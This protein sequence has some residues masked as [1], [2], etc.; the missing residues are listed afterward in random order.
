[1]LH[2][3]N[4]LKKI[5]IIFIILILTG[6]KATYNLNIDNT[7]NIKEITEII[8]EKKEVFYKKNENL[9]D[10][11]P[12]DYLKTDLKWPTPVLK[13]VEINPY[14]PIKINNTNYYTK[15]DL[16]SYNRIGIRYSYNFKKIEYEKSNILNTC[17]DYKIIIKDDKIYFKTN[18]SFKC[19]D[20]YKLL[21]EVT[22]NLNTTCKVKNNNADKKEEKYIWNITKNNYQNKTI[23]FELDCQK[24]KNNKINYYYII[25]VVTIYVLLIILIYIL[26]KTKRKKNN[27]I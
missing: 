25:I 6:C 26:A 1:M 10:V 5:S 23:E 4:R 7:A 21:E 12:S 18:S 9:Y 16:S 24:E 19:F 3:F 15:S 11:T 14:E 2:I 8:E 22:F 27:K 17:Y 13:D 20:K